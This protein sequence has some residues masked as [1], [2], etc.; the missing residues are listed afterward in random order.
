MYRMGKEEPKLV[1]ITAAMKDG[2][3]LTPFAKK[4]PDRFLMSEL[5]KSMRLLLQQDLQQQG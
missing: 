1:A 4:Y 3:G 2:T 5:Q